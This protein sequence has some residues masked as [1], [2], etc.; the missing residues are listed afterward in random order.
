MI[1]KTPAKFAKL[2]SRILIGHLKT[3]LEQSCGIILCWNCT[4]FVGLW[5]NIK[6]WI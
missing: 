6:A 1:L 4:Y 3:G 2:K 5:P